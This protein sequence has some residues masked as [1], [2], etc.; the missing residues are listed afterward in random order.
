VRNLKGG[1]DGARK[2]GG[3]SAGKGDGARKGEL[4]SLWKVTKLREAMAALKGH[5]G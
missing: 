2:G 4:F 1:V 3:G 5:S